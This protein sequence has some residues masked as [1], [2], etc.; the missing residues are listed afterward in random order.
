MTRDER[1][2][3]EG[4]ISQIISKEVEIAALV[5]KA[6]EEE[7]DL[8]RNIRD[9]KEKTKKIEEKCK[10]L[11][12]KNLVDLIIHRQLRDVQTIGRHHLR[13]LAPQLAKIQTQIGVALM[14]LAALQ[15]RRL[16]LSRTLEEKGMLVPFPKS[17]SGALRS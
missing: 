9:L 8:S 10:D 4:E 5:Y 16:F 7:G 15:A 1:I 12:K 11:A 6:K 17:T 14:E 3:T 13:Q 2:A